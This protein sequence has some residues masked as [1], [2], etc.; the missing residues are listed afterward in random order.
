MEP[1]PKIA[2]ERLQAAAVGEHPDAD[3]LTAYAEQALA[4]RERSQVAEHLSRCADCRRVVALTNEITPALASTA[5][6]AKTFS[7]KSGTLLSWPILRWGALAACVVIVS[8]AGLLLTRR[9][10]NP[11]QLATISHPEQ[12]ALETDKQAKQSPSPMA[13]QDSVANLQK[14]VP[15]PP[16]KTEVLAR[17]KPP[18]PVEDRKALAML[19]E[20]PMEK[21]DIGALASSPGLGEKVMADKPSAASAATAPERSASNQAFLAEKAPPPTTAAVSVPPAAAP[22]Q[23]TE[24]QTAAKEEQE[25]LPSVSET[26]E[27]TAAAPTLQTESVAVTSK[28]AKAKA[29]AGPAANK[30]AAGAV[31]NELAATAAMTSG[32]RLMDYVNSA[33]WTLS[34]DGLPQRSFNGGKTWEPVQVDH[35]TGFRALSAQ[36]VDVW[37]GGL[38]GVLYHS[39]DV[40]MHWT[41]IIPVAADSTLTADVLTLDFHDAQH[42]KLTTSNRE[43][44]TTSDAGKTWQKQ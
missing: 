2:R 40:G 30:P 12:V 28:S 35:H 17:S 42:G 10:H 7:A 6:T 21:K 43:T 19:R 11:E 38:A 41:R 18:A 8:A 4:E 39:S 3:L 13:A 31:Q 9:S 14:Q 27:V 23:K 24:S 37:V 22:E 20:E 33:K 44:W 15:K 25:R 36:G 1:L 5:F 32:S 34:P 16:T 26:L 29:K